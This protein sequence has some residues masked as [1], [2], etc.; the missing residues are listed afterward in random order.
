MKRRDFV[1][2]GVIAAAL[3]PFLNV[4]EACDDRSNEKNRVF[5]FIQLVG[6]NDGLNTLIPLDNYGNLVSARPNLFI[7]EHKVLPLKGTHETGLH[8]SLEGIREMYANDLIGFVQGVGYEKPSYSHFRSADIWLTGSASSTTLYT[9]WMARFLENR[10]HPFSGSVPAFPPAIK[11]GETGT[12]L[13]EGSR[14]DLGLVIDPAVMDQEPERVYGSEAAVPDYAA[15][16]LLSIKETLLQTEF[17]SKPMNEALRVPFRHS[18]RYPEHGV[19]VLAD[20]LKTVAKLIHSGIGTSVYHVEL[21]GFDTH[22]RQVDNSNTT[23]GLHADLLAKLSQAVT[24]FWD[25]MVNMGREKEVAGL[26][27]SE[28]GRR[29]ASNAS[30][31]TDH[32]SSQP[33]MLFGAN[34]QPGIVGKNPYIPN[35]VE[36]GDSVDMQHDFKSVYGSILKDWFRAKPSE[37]D[38]AVPFRGPE[39]NLFRS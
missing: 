9:G 15:N 22:A 30:F 6:G 18:T 24:C 20:Q 28:F 13:F 19:N 17:Y 38:S 12:V 39:I 32:G 34:V 33:L 7:P 14:M 3:L 8:P 35:R 1:R 16:E 23:R 4:L 2:N 11:V 21:K 26:V 5:V 10:Y 31:G 29:I 25:D 27:F 37:M 36:W